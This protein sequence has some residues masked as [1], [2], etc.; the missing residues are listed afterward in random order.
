MPVAPVDRFEGPLGPEV[1]GA[2]EIR[3]LRG[4]ARTSGVLEWQG[5]EE[6]RTLLLRELESLGDSHPDKSST[7]DVAFGLSL[8]HIEHERER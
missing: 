8:D 4:I 5:V 6:S 2:K 1:V 3:H 7:D